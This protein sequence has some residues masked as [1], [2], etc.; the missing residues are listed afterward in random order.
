MTPA[1]EVGPSLLA[2]G[3]PP[4][5]YVLVVQAGS[6]IHSLKQVGN[7]DNKIAIVVGTTSSQALREAV[8]ALNDAAEDG[9]HYQPRPE[10]FD[11]VE[12]A[13]AGG[14]EW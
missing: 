11:T 2:P 4:S 8:E 6:G 9:E 10:R 12:L 3:E 5:A 7:S 14:P 1:A 13:P